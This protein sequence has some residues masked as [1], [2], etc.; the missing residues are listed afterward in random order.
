MGPEL[1]EGEHLLDVEI[2]LN[3]QKYYGTLEILYKQ[4]VEANLT[5]DQLEKMDEEDA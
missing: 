2:F 1:P 4:V 3:G 5:D